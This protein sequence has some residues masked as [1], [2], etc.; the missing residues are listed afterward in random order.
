MGLRFDVSKADLAFEAGLGRAEFA[1]FRDIHGLLTHVFTRLEPH[2]LRLTDMRTE[3]GAGTAADFHV[4]CYL[5]NLW[6]TVRIR[7]DRIEVFCSELPQEYVQRIMAAIVDTLAAVRDHFPDLSFRSHTLSVGLHGL[8][9]GRPVREY[10]SQF[11]GNV[12]SGLGAMIGNGA[13][14]YFGP[15]GE[16]LLSSVTVDMSAVIAD[17]LYT[18]AHVVWDAQKVSIE[19]FPALGEGFVREALSRL[20]LELQ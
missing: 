14:F 13:V 7:L 9:Q 3:S 15:E 1:L 8:L 2:G 6:M 17:A 11:V 18:R 12:P 5:F 20:G 4:L 16:R 19:V 10:L